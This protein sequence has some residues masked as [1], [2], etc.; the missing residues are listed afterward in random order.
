MSNSDEVLVVHE[1]PVLR[2]TL[3]RPDKHNPLSRP[4]LAAL[5]AAFTAAA[6]I[7]GLGCVVLRGAGSRYFAAGGDLRDL[8]AVRTEADTRAMAEEASAA[9]DAVRECPVP[10]V[11]VINGDAIG[12]GAELAV[13]CDFRVMREGAHIGFIHGKLNITAAWGG[14][15][16]LPALVGPTRALRMTTRCEL[17][18]AAT[19]VQ[20]GL[21]DL[22]VAEGA[23]DAAVN[24][25]I[26]PMLKQTPA[27]LR[28]CKRQVRAYR[29]GATY[30]EL[31]AIEQEQFVGTW[32]HDDH[33]AAVDRILAPRE[34]R[35]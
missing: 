29:H 34:S 1:G 9:L 31:R 4:V 7:P 8:A 15:T 3:N 13:S 24:D 22:A 12:G 23:L 21:A 27:A 5:R 28:A 19:A 35:Q 2:V 30:R 16:D 14:G 6:E 17:V 33:W 25:F 10:V 11:A 26:A 32:I 20:W 18:E